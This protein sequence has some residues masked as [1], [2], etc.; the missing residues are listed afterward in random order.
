[1][2]I[3]EN[4]SSKNISTNLLPLL[5]IELIELFH[6]EDCILNIEKGCECDTD[7]EKFVVLLSSMNE[8]I[9]NG[10]LRTLR[11]FPVISLI[12]DTKEYGCCSDCS[13]ISPL[14][15]MLGSPKLCPECDF[16]EWLLS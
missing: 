3:N 2:S 12:V 11:T 1:M 9:E 8:A 15:K 14:S 7:N 10:T 4:A 6:N 16:A 5:P 13:S